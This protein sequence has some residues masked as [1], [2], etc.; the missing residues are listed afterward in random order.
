M[1]GY[2]NQE[3]SKSV[4]FRGARLLA[5]G[6]GHA[7]TLANTEGW[8]FTIEKKSGTAV[9]PAQEQQLRI[10]RKA[11]IFFFSIRFWRDWND[12]TNLFAQLQLQSKRRHNDTPAQW[13]YRF[14]QASESIPKFGVP[15]R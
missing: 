15:A 4:P 1:T 12:A 14:G 11:C 3:M 8:R 10:P 9:P 5:T 7:P 6:C 13:E 2:E